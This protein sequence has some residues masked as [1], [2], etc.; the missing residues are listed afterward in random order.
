MERSLEGIRTLAELRSKR[1]FREIVLDNGTIFILPFE[2]EAYVREWQ[3]I[4]LRRF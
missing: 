2:R 4:E 1:V 3:R